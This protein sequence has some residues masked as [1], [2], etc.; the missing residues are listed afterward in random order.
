MK[1]EK[2]QKGGIDNYA[3]FKDGHVMQL[4]QTWCITMLTLVL[5][6]NIK[7]NRPKT[8]FWQILLAIDTKE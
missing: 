1:A 6:E 7:K 3:N 5:K 4:C 2:K 8:D